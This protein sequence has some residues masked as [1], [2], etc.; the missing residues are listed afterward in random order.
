MRISYK[1]N[2]FCNIV[3]SDPKLLLQMLC[4]FY[5]KSP[6]SV[7]TSSLAAVTFLIWSRQ[8]NLDKFNSNWEKCHF[9]KFLILYNIFQQLPRSS[10]NQAKQLSQSILQADILKLCNVVCGHFT[11]LALFG[12]PHKLHFS[13]LLWVFTMLF[14]GLLMIILVI[15]V[16][17]ATEINGCECWLMR[18][19]FSVIYYPVGRSWLT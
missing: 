11:G 2:F 4:A 3:L 12:L 18:N 5:F 14:Y 17:Y 16:V 10:G 8:E 19:Y 7:L 6:R 15:F 9:W 1:V 13:N